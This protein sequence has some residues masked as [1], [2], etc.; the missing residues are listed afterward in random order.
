LTEKSEQQMY[1][2]RPFFTDERI[3]HKVNP[4]TLYSAICSSRTVLS[5]NLVCEEL[6]EGAYYCAR[7][8]ERERFA[9]LM[10]RS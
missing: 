4:Q 3:W 6:P 10:F 7:C 2:P 9:D 8:A 1:A 5:C